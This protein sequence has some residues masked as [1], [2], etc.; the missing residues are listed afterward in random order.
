MLLPQAEPAP[1]PGNNMISSGN[2]LI[3]S[4]DSYNF[5]ASVSLVI[6]S[7]FTARSGLPTSPK[8]SVSPVNR[9]K[10]FY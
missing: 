9:Y 2:Y 3:L 8:K 5:S 7:D 6:N 4:I 1:W 10:G